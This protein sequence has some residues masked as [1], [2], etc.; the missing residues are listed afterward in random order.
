MA[1]TGSDDE[2]EGQRADGPNAFPT[3]ERWLQRRR[4][5]EVAVL[6][7]AYSLLAEEMQRRTPHRQPAH[8]RDSTLSHPDAAPNLRQMLGCREV[9]DGERGLRT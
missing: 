1:R 9:R 6:R 4:D 8:A 2:H 5:V 3:A 7:H